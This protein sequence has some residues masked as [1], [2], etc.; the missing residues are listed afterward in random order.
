MWYLYICKK[1]ELFYTG[2]TTDVKNRQRQHGYPEILHIE[3]Y[4]DKKD[5]AR[6]EKQIKGWCREKKEKLIRSK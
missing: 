5:A 1:G 2:I 4:V 3:N 6:R